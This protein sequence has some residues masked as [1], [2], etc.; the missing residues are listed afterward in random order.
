MLVLSVLSA[1]R[2]QRRVT[3]IHVPLALLVP[4]PLLQVSRLVLDPTLAALARERSLAH[5][6]L[7]LAVRIAAQGHIS[8]LLVTY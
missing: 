5:H 6:Q 1:P 8:L 4:L 7:Q 2:S 3:L